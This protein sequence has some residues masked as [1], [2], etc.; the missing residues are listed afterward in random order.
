MFDQTLQKLVVNQAVVPGLLLYRREK[1]A[2]LRRWRRA[3][4][5]P[6]T[7]MLIGLVMFGGF[8]SSQ[9]NLHAGHRAMAAVPAGAMIDTSLPLIKNP[10][11]AYDRL[12]Q[13]PEFILTLAEPDLKSIFH[14][15]DLERR[16]G[17]VVMM[18]FRGQDCVLDV[19]AKG[20]RAMH[21]EFRSRLVDGG[22]VTRTRN[23]LDDITKGRRAIA[24]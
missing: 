15:A 3:M 2:L 9:G 6:E 7:V 19:Y 14:F 20:G 8:L 1:R 22:D 16:D 21:Y 18:Q 23:C 4:I 11:S 13:N 17:D 12:R 10:K 5:L 24:G